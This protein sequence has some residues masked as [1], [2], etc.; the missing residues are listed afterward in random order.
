MKVVPAELYDR[1]KARAESAGGVGHSRYYE[2]GWS[3]AHL[4]PCCIH[5]CA[6]AGAFEGD[7]D[8]WELTVANRKILEDSGITVEVNDQ[9][10]T[11]EERGDPNFRL[12]WDEFCSRVGVV[13]GD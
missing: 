10:F 3:G 6:T 13:R 2:D 8:G 7:V 1:L 9:A 5:G 4:I 12:S 11:M